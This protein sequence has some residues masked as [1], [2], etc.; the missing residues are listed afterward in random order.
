MANSPVKYDPAGRYEVKVEDLEYRSDGERSWLALT[1]QPQGPGPFPALLEIH[2]GAWN[3]GDRRNNPALAEGLAASGV[4]VASIDFRMGGQDPYPSSLAD[5]NYATRWLKVQAPDFKADPATVGGLGVSSGG[6]LILLSAMRPFDP[7]Y[8]ALPF[9]GAAGVD[10]TL[11]YAISLWGVL[12]PY[13]RYQMAQEKGNKELMANHERYFLTTDTMRESNLI[14]ILQ[15]K[16]KVELPPALL[17]QGTADK[18]VPQGMVE[19]VNELYRA[20]GGDVELALFQDMPHGLAGWSETE[21]A[22][23]IERVKAFIAK[24]VTTVTA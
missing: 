12:D 18:G 19:K 14:Q 22:R 17:I 5:I 13:G 4:V 10:G 15:N 11:A 1:Y 8:T 16:E 6:H 2:G 3:N 20:A 24:Q 9:A 7:R 23:M 21:A